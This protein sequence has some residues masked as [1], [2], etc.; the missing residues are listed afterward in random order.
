MKCRYCSGTD[1]VEYRLVSGWE[2]KAQSASRRSG[3]DIVCRVPQHANNGQPLW[4]CKWCI[5]KLKR[6]VGVG[7][8]ELVP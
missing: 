1:C 8:E 2:R 3:S 4:A 6:G 5:Q 7:Q